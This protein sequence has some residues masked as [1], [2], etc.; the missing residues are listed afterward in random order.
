MLA[1][2]E[3]REGQAPRRLRNANDRPERTGFA[4]NPKMS[5]DMSIHMSGHTQST[6]NQTIKRIEGAT[7]PL[8]RTGSNVAAASQLQKELHEQQTQGNSAVRRNSANNRSERVEG[9][10]L[11]LRRTGSNA[12]AASQEGT[13]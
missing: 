5:I 6:I 2:G 4:Y 13:A 10:T 3:T 8:R 12:A 11:P 7:L 9:A 1:H